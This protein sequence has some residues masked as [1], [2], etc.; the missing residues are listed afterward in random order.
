MS[1]GSTGQSGHREAW[2][3]LAPTSRFRGVFT[4]W[5]APATG[6]H[7]RLGRMR[8]TAASLARLAPAMGDIGASV[9]KAMGRRAAYNFGF[10]PAM[11]RLIMTHPGF[12]LAF[13]TTFAR[14]M[15]GPSALSRAEREAIAA[16][17][18]RAQDCF[19]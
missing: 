2:V 13:L 3:E 7:E 11:G 17:A 1:N 19:Y 6:L 16:V 10:V 9:R 4:S 14:V 18:A 5:E 12:G 8:T 15:F